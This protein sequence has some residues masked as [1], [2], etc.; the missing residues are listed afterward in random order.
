MLLDTHT[1]LWATKEPELL[2]V[3][4]ADLIS[5]TDNTVLVSAATAWEISIKFAKGKFP[6]AEFLVRDYYN[7]LAQYHF[8]HLD[9]TPLHALR[10]PQLPGAHKD[11]FDRLIAAQAILEGAV[12]VS[13]DGEMRQFEGLAV[14]W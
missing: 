8:N 4:A 12:L 14:E 13:G 1:L 2:S 7:V 3:R 9:I 10:A 5:D 11:P 6:Q